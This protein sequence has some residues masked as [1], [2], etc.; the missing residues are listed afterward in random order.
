MSVR[1]VARETQLRSMA[2]EF[3]LQVA[4]HMPTMFVLYV[5]VY[6]YIYI[7]NQK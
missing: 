2:L 1:A 3:E 4:V 6:I 5:D 7:V